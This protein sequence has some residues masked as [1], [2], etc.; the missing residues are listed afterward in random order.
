MWYI[1]YK[2]TCQSRLW[3][4][5][6]LCLMMKCSRAISRVEW[7]SGEKNQR[8]QDHLCPRP[9]GASLIMVGSLCRLF[10]ADVAGQPSLCL[11]FE[12][13]PGLMTRCLLLVDVYCFVLLFWSVFSVE[14][15]VSPLCLIYIF[16]YYTFLLLLIYICFYYY[17]YM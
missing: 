10:A 6:R 12:P 3:K 17:L 5:D 14:M 15:T 11:G 8:F 4:A 1:M 7:L 2:A 13:P 16:L 9:Q